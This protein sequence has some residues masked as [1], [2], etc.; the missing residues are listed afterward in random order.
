MNFPLSYPVKMTFKLLALAPQI[1]VRDA[2][3]AEVM[4]VRQKLLKLKEEINVFSDESQSRRTYGIK[5][6]RIL[7]WSARYHI[8]D[9]VGR[10]LGAVKRHGARSLWRAS[11]DVLNGDQVEFQI[12]EESAFVRLMDAFFGELP[13]L[14]MFSGYVFNPVYLASRADALNDPGGLVMRMV[15]KPSLLERNFYIEKADPGLTAAEEER[16]LLS[17]F[18]LTLLERARG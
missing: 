13:I 15:K 17:L 8:S 18:M 3:G 14:G 10:N 1:S 16:L 6:D 2:S 4:Y 11:Y 12:R 9:D 7:D 5:A